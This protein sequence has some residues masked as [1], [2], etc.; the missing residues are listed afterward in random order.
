[1]DQ[2]ET[3]ECE[4]NNEEK[5][6]LRGRVLLFQISVPPAVSTRINTSR[7]IDMQMRRIQK[8]NG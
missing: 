5:L 8:L 4:G 6:V 1:M 2:R 3:R 7:S